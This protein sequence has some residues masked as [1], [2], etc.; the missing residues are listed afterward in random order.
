M[1]SVYSFSTNIVDTIWKPDKKSENEQWAVHFVQRKDHIFAA[2]AQLASHKK[3][4]CKTAVLSGI[5]ETVGDK[6][7]ALQCIQQDYELLLSI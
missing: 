6:H 1:C 3:D 7:Q 2:I 4:V 5:S